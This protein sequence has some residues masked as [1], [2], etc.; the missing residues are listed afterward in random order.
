MSGWMA[1]TRPVQVDQVQEPILLRGGTP[2]RLALRAPA[3]GRRTGSGGASTGV[4]APARPGADCTLARRPGH[5]RPGPAHEQVGVG[6]QR[7]VTRACRDRVTAERRATHTMAVTTT[8]TSRT[9]RTSRRRR[10]ALSR[11]A[12]REAAA[13]ASGR[14]DGTPGAVAAVDGAG[15]PGGAEGV[16][17]DAYSVGQ[18]PAPIGRWHP[19][20]RGMLQGVQLVAEQPYRIPK[21]GRRDHTQ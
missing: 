3:A 5:C 6:G 12:L 21:A 10:R 20:R 7:D 1:G 17:G 18:R 8:A 13:N 11:L 9:E 15:S 14:D 2:Y 4:A 16:A 19:C